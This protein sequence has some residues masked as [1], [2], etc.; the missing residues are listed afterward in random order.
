M[1]MQLAKNMFLWPQQSYVRKALEVPLTLT[2][3]ALWSKARIAEIY[4]NIVEWGPGIFG[5]EA[6]AR[7]HFDRSAEKL[8]TRQ[9]ALLAVSLPSPIRRKPGSP[10][11]LMNKMASTIIARMRTMSNADACVTEAR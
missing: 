1:T 3:D 9:A 7:R 10:S 2:I 8:T 6:A 11:R 5:A 4:L